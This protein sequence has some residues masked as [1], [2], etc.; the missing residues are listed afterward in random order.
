MKDSVKEKGAE[1]EGG[2]QAEGAI[3][4][5]VLALQAALSVETEEE[6]KKNKKKSC[7]WN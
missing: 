4:Y 6:Q 3:C 1:R 5:A 7:K 2:R